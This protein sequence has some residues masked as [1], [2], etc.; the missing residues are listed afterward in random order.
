MLTVG[1]ILREPLQVTLTFVAWY[2]EQG[3]DRIVLCFDD[4]ADPAI[5]V[6]REHD[7]VECLPCTR[8]FWRNA[9]ARPR[10]RFTRRQN[11]AMQYIYDGLD[12]GW[13][14]NVDGDEL[15][16]LE[17]RSLKQELATQPSAVRAVRIAPAEHIQSAADRDMMQFRLPMQRWGCRQVYGGLGHAMQGRFGLTGHSEGKSATRVGLKGFTARQ[18]FFQ[19]DAGMPLTDRYLGPEDGAYLL[20]FMENSFE[21]WRDKLEWRLRSRGFRESMKRVIHDIMERPDAEA[22]LRDLYNTLYVFDAERLEVL[23]RARARFEVSLDPF[24]LVDA[25]F[26]SPSMAVAA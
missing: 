17:G 7:R 20:H 23:S 14:L 4:P 11:L 22:G 3:A 2:L 9:Q 18:H 10:W 15:V 8:R 1:A 6:L 21:Y 5:E 16:Y 12:E 13:F 26:P 25:H 19:T 24:S